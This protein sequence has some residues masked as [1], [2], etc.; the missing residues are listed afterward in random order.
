MTV[1]LSMPDRVPRASVLIVRVWFEEP[2]TAGLGPPVPVGDDEPAVRAR[3]WFTAEVHDQ[4]YTVAT[5]ASLADLE[6][7]VG[8]WLGQLRRAG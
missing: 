5:V 4:P 3:V 7:V 8:R 1:A 6:E 2:Q